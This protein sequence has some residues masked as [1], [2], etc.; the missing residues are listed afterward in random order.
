LCTRLAARRTLV[1]A[2]NPGIAA[3]NEDERPAQREIVV[4]PEQ[5][6]REVERKDLV[7]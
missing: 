2:R 4:E 6:P 7:R 5:A 3:A 1:R